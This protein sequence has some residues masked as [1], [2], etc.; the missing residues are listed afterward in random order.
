MKQKTHHPL[1]PR[2]RSERVLLTK[3]V[4]LALLLA[5]L[6]QTVKA[7]VVKFVPFHGRIPVI[8]GFFDITHITNPGAAWGVFA[9][10][11]FFLLTIS[12]FVLAALVVFFRPLC[13]D[14][15]ERY[16]ALAL[17][18]SGILGNSFD[19]I[20]RAPLDTLCGGEVVDF[21]SFHIGRF[22]W[23]NFNVA[24]SCICIGVGLFIL[25]SFLRPG[26]DGKKSADEPQKTA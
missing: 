18:V 24:D 3:A 16:Y 12:L 19:R 26:K 6:D 9:G 11:G 22:E 14:W 2:S 21:L 4:L 13:E 15:R 1:E 10:R 5:I 25:S 8:P 20:F 17:I 7:L 23:P